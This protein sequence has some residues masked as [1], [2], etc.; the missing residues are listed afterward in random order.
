MRKPRIK[1]D[2][3]KSKLKKLNKEIKKLENNPD[4]GENRTQR[5]KELYE[6]LEMWE[7][8]LERAREIENDRAKKSR[9]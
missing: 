1:T 9:G 3:I 8:Q 4:V 2:E 5:K 7:D 6:E